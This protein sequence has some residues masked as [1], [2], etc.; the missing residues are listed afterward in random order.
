IFFIYHHHHH[1]KQNKESGC[2]YKNFA[3]IT[4]EPSITRIR[5]LVVSVVVSLSSSVPT[6]VTSS[7]AG[8]VM[9]LSSSADVRL[10]VSSVVWLSAASNVARVVVAVG[11]IV[12]ASVSGRRATADSAA[13]GIAGCGATTD[14]TL[15]KNYK[16]RTKTNAVSVGR[17]S[18]ADSAAV[19][20]GR[21]S[22]A[23]SA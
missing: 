22:T 23:N 21:G 1:Y 3:K 13:I 4:P 17:G 14:T 7:V 12:A 11:V 19:S 15:Q 6:V 9:G 20:V 2:L 8:S 10:R 18:T 5:Q 16:K